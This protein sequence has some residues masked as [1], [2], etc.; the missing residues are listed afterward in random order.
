[1][2]R[3]PDDMGAFGGGP[4]IQPRRGIVQGPRDP[5]IDAVA[6]LG[7]TIGKIGEQIQ[8]RDDKLN[9]SR[10]KTEYLKQ[11]I[12]IESSF[13]NDS[14]YATYGERYKDKIGKARESAVGL[15]RNPM[16]RE[17]FQQD[18][19]IDIEQGLA[20]MAKKAFARESDN[21]RAN[22]AT[23]LDDNQKLILST[24]DPAIRASAYNN[25]NSAIDSAAAN[26]W[27]DKEASGNLKRK[28][29][30]ES[31]LGEFTAKSAKDQ[32][33]ML[34]G[35]H[36][37][38]QFI[39]LDKRRALEDRAKSA[40]TS[41][42]FVQK[43][44][45]NL[46]KAETYDQVF[47]ALEMNNGDIS[48][49]PANVLLSLS[50]EQQTRTHKHASDLAT[51]KYNVTDVERYHDLKNFAANP[52]TRQKFLDVD[53]TKEVF[54]FA[55]A[56]R[57]ELINLQAKIRNK[58]PEADKMLDGYRSI[59]QRLNDTLIQADVNPSPKKDTDEA[60]SLAMLRDR[61]ERG[62]IKEKERLGKKELTADEEQRVI[63]REL[64][65]ERKQTLFGWGPD[66]ESFLFQTQVDD[67][68]D[69]D[70]KKIEAALTQLGQPVND[71]NIIKMYVQKRS[72]NGGK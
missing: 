69:G 21:G 53:L 43:R 6:D 12:Q 37:A 20:G 67:I 46:Q 3:I 36:P 61:V 48:A 33:E 62:V 4:A 30:E 10:A 5:S 34:S 50:P 27:L 19:D 64:I 65:T 44:I 59:G 45:E 9:Y 54:D 1:M 71:A 22:L 70:R 28:F 35:N 52:A 38:L 58:D 25:V 68:P 57:K 2:P 23:V 7:A 16:L 29:A 51:G 49:I 13:E 15:I 26:N 55:P 56:D 66:K 17:S 60:K 41:Q 63:D 31:A 72:L 39:P 47:D 42:M 32:L 18:T 24:G 11:K 14:D 40:I 8:D